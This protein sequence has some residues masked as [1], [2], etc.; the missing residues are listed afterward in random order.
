MIYISCKL[1]L[2]SE[3]D[4]EKV[5]KNKQDILKLGLKQIKKNIKTITKVV[6]YFKKNLRF[7][8]F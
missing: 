3:D 1:S 4:I 8:L 2:M 6:I 7:F 5:F